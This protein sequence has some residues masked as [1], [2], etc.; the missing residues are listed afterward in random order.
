ML[1]KLSVRNFKSLADVSIVLPRLSVLFG[2]NAAGKSNILDAVHTLSMVGT[3][4]TLM[5]GLGGPMTRG[6]PIEAF[7]LPDNGIAGLISKPAA[8]F[9]LEADLGIDRVNGS[10][11]GN[12]RYRIDVEIA[13]NSGVLSNCHEYLAALTK[14]GRPKGIPAIEVDGN[15]LKIRRQS[16]GGRPRFE[17]LRQNYSILS[18]P[19]L[20]EPAHKYIERARTELLDW[21]TYYFDP[22]TAMRRAMPPADV[23]DIGVFGDYVA[24]FLYK[25]KAGHRKHFDTVIRTVR[26]IIPSID[27]LDVLLDQRRGTLDLFVRQNGI[28]YSARVVSEGT[29]RLIGLCAIAA[30]PW[31]GSLLAFEEPE[32][33][34]HPRRLELIARLLAS[35]SLQQGCQVLV[36]THSPLF[37]SAVLREAW[38]RGDDEIALFNVRRQGKET[39]IDRFEPSGPLFDQAEVADALDQGEDDLFGSL[40][41]RGLI[42]E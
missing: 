1:R 30:S 39:K 40:I 23:I 9:S 24:P 8:T 29:L 31:R 4:R 17:A 16:G 35:V 2:V 42:D 41:L 18:D 27:S 32:N 38:Q 14:G 19:R 37:C 7:G 36:A 13:T 34:V 11:G 3:Q 12:F 6:Y 20:G 10:P 21:R 25:L 33:G 26:A 5:D 22:R 28:D 15:R